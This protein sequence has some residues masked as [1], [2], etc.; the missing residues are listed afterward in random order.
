MNDQTPLKK[1]N[2]DNNLGMKKVHLKTMTVQVKWPTAVR[3][4]G[5]TLMFK[6]LLDT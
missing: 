6:R 2:D 3:A 1:I 4:V 5:P